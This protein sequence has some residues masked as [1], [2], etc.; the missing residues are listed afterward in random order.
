[1]GVV[2]FYGFRQHA[3][4][5]DDAYITYR[6]AR[7]IAWGRGFVYNPG[8]PVLGTTTPLYT[9]LLAGLSLIWSDLPVLSHVIS[10]L[11]WMACVPILF[12]IG[13][14]GGSK[15]VGILAA[16]LLAF[17][18]LFL[19]ALGMETA[20][21]VMLILLTFC[22][23]L[24]DRPIG[25]ALCA[26]LTFLVRWDGILVV[27]VFL[28]AE[29]LKR[30]RSWVRASLVCAGIIIPWLVFSYATFG[31]IFPNSFFAKAGQGWNEGLGGTEIGPFARGLFILA[32]S[33][34]A[35]NRLFVLLPVFATLGAIVIARD[36]DRSWPLFLWSGA[37][38]AGYIA[39]GVL[40]FPWYY[41]PLVP[42]FV[43][44]VAKGVENVA[45]FAA[46]RL[47]R[48]DKQAAIAGLLGVLCLV[49]TVDWLIE[50]SRTEMS[51][52]NQTYVEVGEWLNRNTPP[53]SSVAMIEIGIIGFYS[54]R[55]VVDTMGLVS[56][57]MIGHLDTWVQT[58]KFAVNHYWPDYVVGLER[59][60]WGA[61]VNETWF[62]EAYVLQ[63]QIE[64]GADPVA[65]A[66][67]YR[68]R[69][70]FPP[71]TFDLSVSPAAWFDRKLVLHE[72]QV[73]E[74][75]LEPAGRIRVQLAWEAK[76]DIGTDYRLRFNLVSA[77]DGRLWT[78]A[79]GVQPMRGGNPT[80]QWLEGDHVVD[81][82]TLPVPGD[83]PAGPYL[84][85]LMIIGENG[86]V[87]ASDAAN[88]PINHVAI[89]PMEIGSPPTVRHEPALAGPIVFADTIRLAGLEIETGADRELSVTLYWEAV[90][91]V[92]GDYTVFVHL[93]SAERKLVAQH[94]S[95]PLL[96]TSLWVPGIQVTDSHMLSL[97]AELSS[98]IYQIRV[99]LYPWPELERLPVVAAK[100]FDVTD[101]AVLVG[102]IVVNG[103]APDDAC[104]EI[105]RI[106]MV[107][108]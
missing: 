86:P 17:S 25:A 33:A 60:A 71:R 68:R 9:L 58:L 82:H 50:T 107:D 52:H 55:T 70:G 73:E 88:A 76:E 5:F 98:E 16:S 43:L 100:S 13:Q 99:G 49:P 30:G 19:D 95:P 65:P 69:D 79:D 40:R 4:S 72:L 102:C 26:G 64:N 78:L 66:S 45:R 92:S 31:S 87:G 89:G 106:E 90:D 15:V 53:G 3:S 35:E 28:L 80:Q 38:L 37:Y 84:L 34:Y 32:R 77:A 36:R 18:P 20:L 54:D 62:Q 67:I 41:P 8:E 27:G 2:L 96:P 105:H 10:V 57:E 59:T 1:M 14:H 104:P 85:E 81:A 39:L 56:P 93:L 11:A 97:P 108:E 51:A 94:D 47:W 7:N 23:S 46:P 103:T 29:M 12:G 48:G 21:Y 75:L 74:E 83:V 63:T 42:A 61:I 6:Y 22:L 24:Q 44:L 101:G 91:G